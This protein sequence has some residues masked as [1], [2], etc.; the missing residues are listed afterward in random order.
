MKKKP[1]SG[2]FF[3]YRHIKFHYLGYIYGK[4]S[5]CR[6][7]VANKLKLNKLW[8]QFPT[9]LSLVGETRA[10]GNFINLKRRIILL[11]SVLAILAGLLWIGQGM[12]YIQW[13]P[14]SFMI[15]QPQWS[16]YGTILALAGL[17]GVWWT[18]R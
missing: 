8:K 11:V 15:R 12:G 5:V 6:T 17:L 18:W 14:N 3:G 2:L 13:P 4:V 7:H 9:A 10:W 16:I 1:D